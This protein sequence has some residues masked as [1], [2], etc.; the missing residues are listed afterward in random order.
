MKK[1]VLIIGG[2]GREH[3]LCW[4]ASKSTSKPEI[5]CAP[6]NAGIAQIAHCISIAQDNIEDLVQFAFENQVDLTIVGGETPLAA[7][8]VDAFE[9]QNLRIVGPSLAASRLE[10]SK[11]FAKDFMTRHNI[12]TA[13]YRTANSVDQAISILESGEFGDES[14]PVVIKADGLAGGKGVIV[15]NNRPEAVAAINELMKGKHN[16]SRPIL[17][18]ERLLGRE[19]SLLLFSDG[20]NFA[21]MPPARDYKRISD[22]D[23]GANTGGMGTITNKSLL[24][25]AELR[26][27]VSKM[28]EPT[29]TGAQNE[30]FTFRGILFF[31]LILTSEGVK[32]IEYNVRFGDP[33]AQ[34]ILIRLESDFIEICESIVDEN[35]N[36][37]NVNFS[38]ESSA[39]VVLASRGY[40]MQP[41]TGDVILGLGDQLKDVFVF[42][43]GTTKD[44]TGKIVTSGGRV[45]GLTSKATELKTALKI[46]Y[47]A[48][49]K[50]EWNGII[51]RRDIGS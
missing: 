22:G 8:I 46:V 23:V 41:Q 38:D 49:E 16:N 32:L 4:A 40:P 2:G 39:C 29:L 33:E 21:L 35:L 51:Y 20:K 18:E 19:V 3:A 13:R 5:F 36:Q 45:L 47:A 27:I 30:G 7:G 24:S 11:R 42:H 25:E 48:I 50:I 1:K 37:I 26:E 14:S 9:K 43:A 15:A 6:G 12:P 10:S 31:G 44:Q 34:S 28:I 17:L